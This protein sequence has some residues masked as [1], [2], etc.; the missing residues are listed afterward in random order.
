MT[1]KTSLLKGRDLQEADGN[2]GKLHPQ[3]A[4]RR[5]RPRGTGYL[6]VD[7]ARHA[8]MRRMIEECIVPTITAAAKA[9]VDQAFGGGTRQSKITR[10]VRTYPYR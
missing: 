9:V 1:G 3:A 6:R 8:E 7:A 2:R 10:L 4:K 5:G